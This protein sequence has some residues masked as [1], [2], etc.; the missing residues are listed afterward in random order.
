MAYLYRDKGNSIWRAKIRRSDG[1]YTTRSTKKTNRKEAEKVALELE[2]PFN[3]VRK[4]LATER[5]LLQAYRNAAKEAGLGDMKVLSIKEVFDAYLQSKR[6]INRANATI[7]KY[8]Q[9]IE[10]LLEFLGED[11]AAQSIN[12]LTNSDIENWRNHRIEEGVAGSTA[13]NQLSIISFA[14]GSC[15]RKGMIVENPAEGIER[16]GEGSEKRQTFTHEEVVRL[17]KEADYEWQGMILLGLWYGMRI[18]D[19]SNVK[20]DKVS[21]SDRTIK[22][23]PTKTGRTIKEEMTYFMPDEVYNYVKSAHKKKGASKLLFPSLAG[24]ETGSFGGL[25]N[26]FDRLM[27]RSKIVVPLGVEKDGVGRQFRKKGFHS[28]RYTQASRMA[29]AGISEEFG[30]AISMHK[31]ATI[32]K[33]YVQYTQTLQKDLFS[34]L[35]PV[36]KLTRGKKKA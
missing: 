25:S 27:T 3:L 17:C 21:L 19:A 2:E 22:H 23:T 29:D 15:K 30:M 32:H 24:K 8:K 11:R 5:V 12:T 34:R 31:S 4:G 7:G 16:T 28:L 18:G 10:S 13:D 36:L 1:T 6:I 14:L 9:V 20:W 33:G 35:K 26:A